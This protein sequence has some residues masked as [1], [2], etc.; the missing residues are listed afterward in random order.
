VVGSSNLTLTGHSTVAGMSAAV[1]TGT[2]IRVAVDPA[3]SGVP[4]TLTSAQVAAMNNERLPIGLAGNGR[5]VALPVTFT[6]SWTPL[7]T[8]DQATGAVLDL[9]LTGTRAAVVANTAGQTFPAGSVATATVAATPPS[10]AAR[11]AVAAGLVDQRA[12]HEVFGEVVPALLAAFA[13]VL[14]GFAVPHVLR[15][16]RKAVSPATTA[17]TD[18]AIASALDDD[19][20]HERLT[21]VA[22]RRS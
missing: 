6:D 9:K 21:P 4:T 12:D 10:I 7:V 22:A 11:S 19:S 8:V 17:L 13:A 15:G 5:T 20:N 2:P 16:R 3:R 18:R 14:L 1:Y